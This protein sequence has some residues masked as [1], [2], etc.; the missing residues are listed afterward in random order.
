MDS[1]K[2]NLWMYKWTIGV[3]KNKNKNLKI[4]K[5]DIHKIIIQKMELLTKSENYNVLY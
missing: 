2:H 1:P 3:K 4:K 5:I